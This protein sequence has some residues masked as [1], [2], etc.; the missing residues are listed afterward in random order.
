MR[1]CEKNKNHPVL[2]LLNRN[3]LLKGIFHGLRC[4]RYH[5]ARRKFTCTHD[6]PL[7][8]KFPFISVGAIFFFFFLGGGMMGGGGGGVCVSGGGGARSGF[9]RFRA[10][11]PPVDL[12]L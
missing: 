5:A 3:L 4:D 12:L 2:L 8:D 6:Q 10:K 7:G 1:E 11:Y 9:G